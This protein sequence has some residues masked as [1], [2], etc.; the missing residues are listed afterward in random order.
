MKIK[1]T[2]AALMVAAGVAA[3]PAAAQQNIVQV[4]SGND[5]FETLVQAVT[6]PISVAP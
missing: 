2:I 1:S 6:A 5:N 4:A 3:M